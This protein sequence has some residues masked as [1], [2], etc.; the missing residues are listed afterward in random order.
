VRNHR[1]GPVSTPTAQKTV[2]GWIISGPA[3]MTLYDAASVTLHHRVRYQ[4][5]KFWEDEEI[6]QKL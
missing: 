5:L 1:Q 2:F 3:N 4:Y 6:P